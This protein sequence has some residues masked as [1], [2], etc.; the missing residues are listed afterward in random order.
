MVNLL[1]ALH[2]L[3]AIFIVGPLVHATTT[4]SRGLRHGDAVATASAARVALLYSRVSVVVV[5]LGFGLM[6]MKENGQ[7]IAKFSN[8]WI[9]LSLLLWVVAVGLT[10]AVVAPALTEA[11]ERIAKNEPLDRLATRAAAGGGTVGA[12]FVAIVFLMVYRPGS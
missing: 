12:L 1:L 5:L 3:A 2:V 10:Q 9:W 8:T 6:S 7:Q 11:G 4:A